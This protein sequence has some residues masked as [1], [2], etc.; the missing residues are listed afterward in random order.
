MRGLLLTLLP[1]LHLLACYQR[2][3]YGQAGKHALL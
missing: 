3:H 1:M 2:D